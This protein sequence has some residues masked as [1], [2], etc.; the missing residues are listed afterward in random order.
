[1]ER[2][3]FIKNTGAVLTSIPLLGFGLSKPLTQKMIVLGFDG[4]DHGRVFR[5]LKKGELPNIAR[6]ISN[7]S[8][9]GMG[10]T[11]PPQSP[12]AWG[13]FITGSDPGTYGL[14][15]FVHRDPTNYF[16]IPSHA[17]TFPA[18]MNVRLGKYQIPLKPGRVVLN[19]EGKAFWDYLEDKGIEATIF[20]IPS[21]YPPSK[22]RQKVIA[23][24]GTPDIVGG[25][26][27]YTLFTSDE[28]ESQKDVFPNRIYYAFIDE[29][30]NGSY[31]VDT[32]QFGYYDTDGDLTTI[33][34]V[35]FDADG[36]YNINDIQLDTTSTTII[37]Y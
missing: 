24:M 16:P 34:F 7:G 32:E 19:R 25:N 15:D 37:V 27:E 2:R 8:I 12:V 20:K 18:G 22:S 9:S 3:D 29:N 31:D 21:N 4:M 36:I 10:T 13:S 14:F 1:M 5:L 23:G 28:Q 30:F 35:T 11:I 33:E 17:S 26:G 6:L